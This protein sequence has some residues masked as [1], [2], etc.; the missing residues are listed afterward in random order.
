MTDCCLARLLPGAERRE[1]SKWVAQPLDSKSMGTY[2][3]SATLYLAMTKAALED[4]N[5]LNLTGAGVDCGV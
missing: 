3:S 4:S 5:L 1:A 2:E